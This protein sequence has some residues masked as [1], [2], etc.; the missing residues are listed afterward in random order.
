MKP[1]LCPADFG[2]IVVFRQGLEVLIEL[3]ITAEEQELLNHTRDM[4]S[5]HTHET[6]VHEADTRHT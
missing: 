5:K 2:Y 1:S 4:Q 6:Y 3:L